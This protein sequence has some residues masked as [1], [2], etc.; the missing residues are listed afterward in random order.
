MT[1]QQPRTNAGKRA[2]DLLHRAEWPACDGPG[3]CLLLDDIIAIENEAASGPDLDWEALYNDLAP[4]VG[5]RDTALAAF[6]SR[7]K[8]GDER[9]LAMGE[10]L[11]C[12]NCGALAVWADGEQS[13][14]FDSPGP[15]L[16]T[17][18]EQVID[19]TV[20]SMQTGDEYPD[21]PHSRSRQRI[22]RAA[23]DK[24]ATPRTEG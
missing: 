14:I 15:D 20:R 9:R 24:A 18:I 3:A 6:L 23:F 22:I 11:R 2:H 19:D 21:H 7:H 12:T 8:N 1:E 16:R 5:D 17:I 13:H 10:P 4:L